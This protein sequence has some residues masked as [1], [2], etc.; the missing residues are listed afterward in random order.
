MIKWCAYCQLYKGVHRKGCPLH[1]DNL[2]PLRN[3][4]SGKWICFGDDQTQD[5]RPKPQEN[6]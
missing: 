1:V 2:I 5:S 3:G 4:T 6:K